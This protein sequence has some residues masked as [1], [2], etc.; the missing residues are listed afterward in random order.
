MAPLIVYLIAY[1]IT[2]KKVYPYLSP[3]IKCFQKS[4]LKD[5]FNIGIQFFLLQLSAILL[6]SFANLLIA[7]MF[8]PENVTPYNIAYRYFSVVLMGMNLIMAPIWSAT[9]DAYEKGDL[10]WIKKAKIKTR[11]VLI[12]VTIGIVIMVG[13]SEWV[14]RLWVGSKVHIPFIL[15]ASIGFYV[16]IIIWS[17]SYSSFLNGLGKLRLQTIN[18]VIIAILFIPICG[19]LGKLYGV[20]GI[21]IGMCIP[22]L[23]GLILNKIQFN[24]LIE[25]K[26]SGIWIK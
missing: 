16:C 15:S 26:A 8:G 6:F 10:D 17:M 12:I 14:Y 4:Y 3:S 20:Q 22:N 23:S 19:V 25:N 9:T 21:V 7:H 13:I 18:T 24:K 11:Q 5:L 1:P 2:F